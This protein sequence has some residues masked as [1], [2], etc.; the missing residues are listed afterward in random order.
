M[1]GALQFVRRH[2]KQQS[3][4]GGDEIVEYFNE[5]TYTDCGNFIVW[6]RGICLKGRRLFQCC[7]PDVDGKEPREG[8][9]TILTAKLWAE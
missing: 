4:D 3:F 9:E 6:V 1:R 8:K 7:S 5:S 2:W